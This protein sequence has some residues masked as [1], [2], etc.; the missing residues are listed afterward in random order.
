[1]K[2]SGRG[3]QK[4]RNRSSTVAFRGLR[5]QRP[6]P[7]VLTRRVWAAEMVS[8]DGRSRG[9]GATRHGTLRA[10]R[11]DGGQSAL[12]AVFGVVGFAHSASPLP[13]PGMG[14]A[15]QLNTRSPVEARSITPLAQTPLI[16]TTPAAAP[17]R[18]VHLLPDL[19]SVYCCPTARSLWT[20]MDSLILP[21]TAP[22]LAP[23]SKE[24]AES[25]ED[26]APSPTAS[27]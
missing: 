26:F 3:A 25:I 16:S 18:V 27:R 17:G 14:P 7:L 9:G 11:A 6:R 22:N 15:K 4:M 19:F 20:V 13:D 23:A 21:A 1:M 2:L 10:P 12:R 24:S 8:I 5:R